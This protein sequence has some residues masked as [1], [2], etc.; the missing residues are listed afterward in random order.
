MK[1]K[2]TGNL[3]YVPEEEKE[4]HGNVDYIKHQLSD[5]RYKFCV[6]R[7]GYYKLYFSDDRID[8][9]VEL[10]SKIFILGE[11]VHT[12]L[13]YIGFGWAPVTAGVNARIYFNI[14]NMGDLEITSASL[15]G[16]FVI[17]DYGYLDD[18]LGATYYVDIESNKTQTEGIYNMEFI[19]SDNSFF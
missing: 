4:I 1:L 14:Y 8:E 5:I 16:D 17:S 15:P 3:Y 18:V 7:G 2:L 11:V 19:M 13:K 9:W 10:D 6:E 12:T